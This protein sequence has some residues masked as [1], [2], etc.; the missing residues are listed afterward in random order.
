MDAAQLARLFRRFEQA[1]GVRTRS[2][3]VAAASAWR[4][5]RNSPRR[6]TERSKCDSQPGEGTRFRVRLPLLPSPMPRSRAPRLAPRQPP[7]GGE[8]RAC[9]W[10]KT[11]PPSPKCVVGLLEALGYHAV[12]APH[13]LAALSAVATHAASTLALLDLDLPGMDGFE[14][15]RQ[16]RVQALVAA[17]A[18]A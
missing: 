5:A 10:S 11:M 6:W 8:A 17:A 16:L 18:G 2:G 13:A 1:E 12:H 9:W 7:R 3:A 4:S 15:A 14:L